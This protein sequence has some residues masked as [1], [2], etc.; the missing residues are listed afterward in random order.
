MRIILDSNVLLV[1][2]GRRSRYHPIRRT[3]LD[4]RY[5]LILTNDI[6]FEY[7]EI[8]Q[9]HGAPGADVI[10]MKILA[11]SLNVIYKNSFYEWNAITVDPDDNKFFDVAVAANADYLLTNDGHFNEA[12]KLAFPK[13]TIVTADE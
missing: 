2:I 10:V 1:A 13:V 3:F 4:L 8:L 7:E 9:E 6:L 5:Q 11:D 12:K